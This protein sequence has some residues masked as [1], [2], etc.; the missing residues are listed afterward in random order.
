LSPRALY[1]FSLA[2]CTFDI[3]IAVYA[4]SRRPGVAPILLAGFF[5]V[6]ALEAVRG[7]RRL[8]KPGVRA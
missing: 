5:V 8:R 1:W 4:Y 3:G 2:I 7:L 6:L